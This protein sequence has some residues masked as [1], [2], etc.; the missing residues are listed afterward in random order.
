MTNQ[1]LSDKILE[2]VGGGANVAA[3]ANCMTR[4]R[5][6]LRDA[7]KADIDALK[8]TEGVLGIVEDETL[9]IVLGPGK[10]NKVAELFRAALK[11]KPA[12]PNWE[13][14]KAAA[15]AK[16]RSN[17]ANDFLRLVSNIFTPLLPAVIAG[18]LLSNAASLL[19]QLP[20]A[21]EGTI[22]FTLSQLCLI[23]GNG[24]MAYFAIYTG[25]RA[26]EIFGATPAL[27]GMIGAASVGTQLIHISSGTGGIL[28]VIAGV[29]LIA[30]LEKAI[31]KRVP[32]LLDLILTPLLTILIGGSVYIFILMPLTAWI[33]NGIV[34][35]LTLLTQTHPL[36]S[37]AFGFV[38]SAAF[39]PLV[40]KG[41]HHGMILLYSLQLE[42]MGGVSIFPCLAMAG[43]G[44]VGASLAVYVKARRCNPAFARTIRS[45]LP[46]GVLG[47]GEPLIY[48]VTLPLDKPFRTAGIGAG[49]GGAVCMLL[50]IQ[51]VAWGPSG[52]IATL[53]MKTP[54][55]MGGYLLALLTS[56]TMGFVC[57]WFAVRKEDIDHA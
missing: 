52:I 39:L 54:A 16:Q 14:N 42:A 47:I 9:Q 6:T 56:Y 21:A 41:Y 20:A 25:I 53:L 38:I 4:L 46:A 40:L 1:E 37:M 32:N 22:L 13:E 35:V 10:A 30:K 33:S 27:G 31:R 23:L 15:A 29:W 50:G 5:L 26:A 51:A 49:F 28:G 44:Q 36:I 11:A 2:L 45:A 43:A 48:G 17:P 8:S 57:T 12:S 3:A 34:W 19:S 24:F 18:G 55:M 7:G